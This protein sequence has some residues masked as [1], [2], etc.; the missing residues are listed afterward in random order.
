[1]Q[2][3]AV[4]NKIITKKQKCQKRNWNIFLKKH[5]TYTK[6][7]D[8]YNKNIINKKYKTKTERKK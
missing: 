3:Y 7:L 5:Y 1:M 2:R 8:K 4:N 6:T